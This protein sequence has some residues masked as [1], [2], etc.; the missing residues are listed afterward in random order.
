MKLQK[1]L[2]VLYILVLRAY[3][4]C[5]IWPISGETFVLRSVQRTLVVR[6]VLIHVHDRPSQKVQPCHE[7]RSKIHISGDARNSRSVYFYD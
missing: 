1:Y 5:I 6:F 7:N 4:V 3:Q 2:V